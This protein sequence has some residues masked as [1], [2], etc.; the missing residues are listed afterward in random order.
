MGERSG[1]IL[2]GMILLIVGALLLLDL[3]GIDLGD[4]FGVLIPL[5][6]MVY[7][8]KRVLAADGGRRLWG[9]VAFLFGLLM[10][11]GKLEL[12]FSSLVAAALL[13]WGF[14]L[15]RRSSAAD[16]NLPGVAERQWARSVLGEDALDRW[17]RERT[18]NI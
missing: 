1:K 10:L 3:I 6:I 9:V 8:A 14:R 12:F 16:D 7:G 15:L 17:E 11:I 13:Y 18:G 2:L 5:A 4:I